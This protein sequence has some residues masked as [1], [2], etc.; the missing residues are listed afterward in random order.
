MINIKQ[1]NI[2]IDNLKKT[3]RLIGKFSDKQ[4]ISYYPNNSEE[5]KIFLKS[6]LGNDVGFSDAGLLIN[7]NLNNKYKKPVFKNK[8]MSNVFYTYYFKIENK[9]IDLEVFRNNIECAIKEFSNKEMHCSFIINNGFLFEEVLR[10]I[11]YFNKICSNNNVIS[12]MTFDIDNLNIKDYLRFF[13]YLSSNNFLIP[14]SKGKCKNC[15]HNFT[16]KNNKLYYCDK[17]KISK[18]FNYDHQPFLK[19]YY[20]VCFWKYIT[21]KLNK[22]YFNLRTMEKESNDYGCFLYGNKINS[23]YNAFGDDNF[24]PEILEFI[25]SKAKSDANANTER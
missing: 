10:V 11:T 23:I 8:K 9:I 3:I 16:V 13:Q 7:I 2:V 14:Y 4:L 17:M 21:N 1:K 25:K 19:S 5:L 22:K 18:I 6:F 12:T 15:Q 24:H 20:K